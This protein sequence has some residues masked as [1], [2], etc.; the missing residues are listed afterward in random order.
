MKI[1]DPI[2]KVGITQRREGD[3]ANPS[4]S[5][6]LKV[7]AA[8]DLAKLLS[9]VSY[10]SYILKLLQVDSKLFAV[11]HCAARNFAPSVH[12]RTIQMKF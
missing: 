5:V 9:Y 11:L 8:L 7:K 2:Y 4:L 10:V 3:E 6:T 1:A 12:F